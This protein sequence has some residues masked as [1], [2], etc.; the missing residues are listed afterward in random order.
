MPATNP[1]P[2]TDN[3]SWKYLKAAHLSFLLPIL[4]IA[5]TTKIVSLRVSLLKRLP[6]TIHSPQNIQGAW[7]SPI[8]PIIVKIKSLLRICSWPLPASYSPVWLSSVSLA[9]AALMS[10]LVFQ[11]ASCACPHRLCSWLPFFLENYSLQIFP[12]QEA[13]LSSSDHNSVS[14]YFPKYPIKSSPLTHDFPSLVCLWV[15]NPVIPLECQLLE[16]RV[17]CVFSSHIYRYS[18]NIVEWRNENG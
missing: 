13:L 4:S 6:S 3:S 12:W 18:I 16:V 7:N 11:M 5:Q 2:S 15:Y 1:S 8:V 10:F 14:E 17:L 9:P